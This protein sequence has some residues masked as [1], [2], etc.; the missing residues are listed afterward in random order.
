L[1]KAN[2]P[3]LRGYGV[4]AAN[5]IDRLNSVDIAP[6][7]RQG[8]FER[9]KTRQITAK[10]MVIGT[11]LTP[12]LELA[13][14]IGVDEVSMPLRGGSNIV[15][16]EKLMTSV[17][18][19]FAAGDGASIGG[20]ELSLVEGRIA[21]I[22]AAIHAGM[23]ISK[24][25]GATLGRDRS[26]H[27][28]LCQFRTGLEH[29]FSNNVDWLDLLTPETIICRCED[30]TLGELDQCKAKG[31]TS[32]LQLKAATRIGMGRCQGRNCL[33]T[34]AALTSSPTS[35]IEANPAMPRTRQ[36]AR[37]ILLGDLLHEELAAPELPDDPHLPRQHD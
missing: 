24:H 13:R 26:K 36:P 1:H 28:S 15:T 31:W 12:S 7:N 9:S 17:Q 3:I 18:G 19:V 32:P 33:G 29:I 22:H 6:I 30:V 21:G 34:L 2:I 4:I 8:K 14:L 16:D 23:A 10:T 37:P 27:K 35:D 5:G 20:V 11:G 25:A